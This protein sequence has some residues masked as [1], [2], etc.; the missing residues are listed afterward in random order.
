MSYKVC[1]WHLVLL[2]TLLFS[3]ISGIVIDSKTS[4]PI[5]G[6]NITAD[7]KGT[8]TNLNGEFNLDVGKGT[9][10]QFSHI[11]YK[12]VNAIANDGMRI[13][14]IT[15]VL[16]SDEII[17]HAGLIDEHFQR[18]ASSVTVL[19]KK[20]LYEK[21]KDHFQMVIGNI[22]NLNW[23]GG[24]SRP[25]YFQIRGI[26]ERSH[27]FGEGPPNFSVGFVIDDIDFSGLGMA[28]SLYDIEQVE[29]FKGPQSSVYGS[30]SMAGLISLRSTDPSENSESSMTAT[31]GSDRHHRIGFITN[32]RIR[33]GTFLRVSGLKSYIDGFRHNIS[34]DRN[35]TN[36]RDELFLRA[37][38]MS[39]PI[40]KLSLLGTVMVTDLDNGYDAWA[41]D[42]NEEFKTYSNDRGE[43][44]QS[45][46]A[47]SLRAN[48]SISNELHLT[49]ITTL[50]AT[51]LVHS[52]D[53]DW[54]DSAFWHDNHGFD[55]QVEGWAY[56]FFDKNNRNRLSFT[57]ELRSSI[58]SFIIGSF[59]KHLKEED[60]ASGYL[61][62]GIANNATA[63]Y[64][65]MVLAGY[66]QYCYD[67]TSTLKLQGN[68]RYETNYIEYTG[69]NRS[70]DYFG[71]YM[72]LPPVAFNVNHSMVGFRGFLI[73]MM[74]E[75]TSYY[76]SVSQGYKSGGVNQQPYLSETN[77]PFDPEFIHNVEAGL[78]RTTNKYRTQLVAFYGI[79]KD[80][81]VSISSQQI[82][83]DPNSFIFYTGNATS[84][85]IKGLEWEHVHE[86]GRLIRAKLS[87]GYLNTWVDEFYYKLNA[88][89]EE[90]GGNRDA[91]MAPDITGS[92]SLDYEGLSGISASWGVTFKNDYYFSDSHNEKSE[93]YSLVNFT[94][95]KSYRGLS[96]KFWGRNIL[97]ERYAVRGFH[98]GLIPPEY[99]DQAYFS[100][101]DPIQFGMTLD[102]RF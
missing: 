97:D 92:F 41:P 40:K 15:N 16:E 100:Y 75:F 80:Q 9:E 17:V 47:A 44:S 8:S 81:Q 76:A 11:G 18:T 7:G 30:N 82:D 96:I 1:L 102:H 67:L 59:Y 83:G 86:I 50:S 22:P 21:G 39:R 57:Q 4:Q 70:L 32:I 45:T 74:D 19:R 3:Q 56:E 69:D 51:D 5:K 10:L 54:A 2:D 46:T 34:Q 29:V 85:W 98:F 6:V 99:R 26:G 61:F 55:P 68:A 95:G 101:G 23:A 71:D 73:Y 20:G 64:D 77:R 24:T 36:K 89:T 37:K 62:G 28:G 79:R 53:G 43:D 91:A 78:K 48:Y 93:P 87:L 12:I 63:A 31:Y 90:K 94:V 84:G 27:Y 33:N 25:R 49:S 13:V 52:Y 14:L 58:G 60:K 66:S 35:N 38:V 72:I 65:F 88:G 42:N